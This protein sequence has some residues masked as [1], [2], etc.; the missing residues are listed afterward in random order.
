MSAI[1]FRKG[2]PNS[3]ELH[4]SFKYYIFQE[5]VT[6]GKNGEGEEGIFN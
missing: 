4:V 3:D 5:L 2:Y 6:E 1:V